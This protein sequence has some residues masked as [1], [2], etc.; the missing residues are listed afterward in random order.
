M[1]KPLW[2]CCLVAALLALPAL[3]AAQNPGGFPLRSICEVRS[4]SNADCTQDAIN[5]SVCVEGVV[6]VWQEFGVRG[7]GAIWDPVSGCCISIFDITSA[8]VVPIG[9]KVRV[10]GWTGPFRGLDELVDD[11]ADG[12]PDPVVTDLGPATPAPV[13]DVAAADLMDHS[14]SAEALESC[15]IRLCGTFVDAGTFAGNANYS[16]LG[17]DGNTCIVRIDIDTNLV[18]TPIPAGPVQV[19]AILG[20]FDIAGVCTGYQALP[21][22]TADLQA[23]ADCATVGVEEKTWSGV[24]VLFD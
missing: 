1:R 22:T 9:N 20:Q 6:V 4:D 15:L 24:K 17:S 21:R 7:P 3:V 10:C 8:P 5:D 12:T 23:V 18:G 13:N 2:I 11:P 14:P 16:F 19:T